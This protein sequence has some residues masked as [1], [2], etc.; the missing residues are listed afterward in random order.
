M[1]TI[2]L[3]FSGPLQSWGTKSNFETRHTDF[4]PSKSAVIGIIAAAL[5][6]RRYENEKISKLNELGFAV[7]VDQ[8]GN[9]C[10]D[11]HTAH[12]YKKDGT[13]ERTYVTNRY[14]IEDAVFAVAISHSD[15]EYI[16]KIYTALQHPWFQMFMGR[17][18]LPV[19]YDFI[20]GIFEDGA[21][22]NLTSLEWLAADWYKKRMGAEPV[23][24]EIYIDS[25]LAHSNTVNLRKDIVKSFSQIERKFDFRYEAVLSVS[26]NASMEE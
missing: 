8:P 15:D 24:L 14:Y 17:R 16:R 9:L 10:R 18:A 21:L 19:P 25:N 2:I 12:K 1:K 4:Y 5:G 3:K 26:I 22:E 11:Y 20:V 23:N 7:R 6:Y 13:E